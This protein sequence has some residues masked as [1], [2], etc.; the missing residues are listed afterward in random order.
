[1]DDIRQEIEAVASIKASAQ[2]LLTSAGQQVKQTMLGDW[3]ASQN[4]ESLF[5]FNRMALNQQSIDDHSVLSI[6][7]EPPIP[8]E[9]LIG[10]VS[11]LAV[12]SVA[13]L[14]ERMAHFRNTFVGHASYGQ[15]L[16][17]IA[18]KHTGI[19]NRLI[20]EQSI[21][22]EALSIAVK[23]V[24]MHKR[25]VIDAFDG[26]Y[27][28]AAKEVS[29]HA[30]LLESFP[31]D[32]HILSLIP[33]NPLISSKHTFLDDF[34]P[35]TKLYN[36]ADYCKIAHGQ[37]SERMA[38]LNEVVTDLKESNPLEVFHSSD[39]DAKKQTVLLNVLLDLVSKIEKIQTVLDRDVSRVDV[40]LN[41]I[42]RFPDSA[43]SKF[44]ALEHLHRVHRDECLPEMTRYD[45][46]IREMVVTVSDSKV[47]LTQILRS[48]LQIIAHQQS[49]IATVSPLLNSL[50]SAVHSQSGAFVQLLHVHR[51]GSAWGAALVEIVRRREFIHLFL[52]KAKEMADVLS[53]F[54]LQEE[55]RREIFKNEIFMYLPSGLI[56]GLEDKLPSCDIAISNT[57]DSLPPITRTDLQ[58][59]GKLATKIR[60]DQESDSSLKLEATFAKISFQVDSLSRDFESIVGKSGLSG[61]LHRLEQENAMLRDASVKQEERLNRID[62][63]LTQYLEE[64]K[65]SNARMEGQGLDIEIKLKML[66][67]A[68]RQ[69]RPPEL[70]QHEQ[71][72]S[73]LNQILQF[74][75]DCSNDLR[76]LDSE[77]YTRNH[78][79]LQ[80]ID[81]DGTS[82]ITS[83]MSAIQKFMGILVDDIHWAATL[84]TSM[85]NSIPDST[86]D[87]EGAQSL[88]TEMATIIQKLGDTEARLR[89]CE[90]LLTITQA[91]EAVLEAEL[92]SLKV[93]HKKAEEKQLIARDKRSEIEQKLQNVSAELEKR[94]NELIAAKSQMKGMDANIEDMQTTAD[95]TKKNLD[96]LR[97]QQE[98]WNIVS[99]LSIEQVIAY[100][101]AFVRLIRFIFDEKS[102][103]EL[104]QQKDDDMSYLCSAMLNSISTIE[105]LELEEFIRTQGEIVKSLYSSLV[106][107]SSRMTAS[108]CADR[109]IERWYDVTGSSNN[110]NKPQSQHIAFRNFKPNDLALFL[111]TRNP[112]AWAAF[113]VNSPHFFL[114]ITSDERFAARVSKREWILAY[115]TEIAFHR[116]DASVADSNPF[117][118]AE[119][120][121]YYV[122][123]GI[124]LS[125]DN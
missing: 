104:I 18:R 46:E 106:A 116:V 40:S 47:N 45:R 39:Y 70:L 109:M 121:K 53:R 6:D 36:W 107:L 1:M 115:V 23:N 48:Q 51:M 41:D 25:T 76:D 60:V 55:K 8:S 7:I 71:L 21:Q 19:C 26:F 59:F 93:L 125:I 82:S 63:M 67:T 74:M 14:A 4:A 30:G 88:A 54:R 35:K 50:S 58:E 17:S 97:E 110:A 92:S 120:T 89:E 42:K 122:C 5:L 91:N 61:Q 80:Q 87:S 29:R 64:N 103:D 32:L 12:S 73:F 3:I 99:R 31:T 100:Q 113:N 102:V 44:E 52:T 78:R 16:L 95:Y 105:R 85:K 123:S 33:V 90:N 118:L 119:G 81:E 124:A 27:P 66:I 108:I 112:K 11:K 69:T 10:S 75:H 28:H 15:S 24:N 94:T 68:A 20:E 34:V 86:E 83:M 96:I 37:L 49:T 57:K 98:D 84:V 9:A 111:P 79:T 62:T 13:S 114:D 43:E 56:G 65:T 38:Q 117:G 72:A 2:I 101:E 77:N 22:S